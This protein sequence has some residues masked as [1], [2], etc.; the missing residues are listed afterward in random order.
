M[1]PRSRSVRPYLIQSNEV[2]K[3]LRKQRLPSPYRRPLAYTLEKFPKNDS[4]D[5]KNATT[6]THFSPPLSTRINVPNGTANSVNCYSDSNSV[7]PSLSNKFL[8]NRRRTS[9]RS[10]SVPPRNY[11]SSYSGKMD[12]YDSKSTY[13]QRLKEGF[14][15]YQQQNGGRV[16]PVQINADEKHLGFS[17]PTHKRDYSVEPIDSKRFSSTLNVNCGLP[18]SSS[19]SDPYERRRSNSIIS[20]AFSRRQSFSYRNGGTPDHAPIP[21]TN[22]MPSSQFYHDRRKNGVTSTDCE[23]DE[24]PQFAELMQRFSDISTSDIR[25][26]LPSA[27]MYQ[28]PTKLGST[29]TKFSTSTLPPTPSPYRPMHN[30]LNP[31]QPR[32]TTSDA[33]P[34]FREKSAANDG[35]LMLK[36]NSRNS[37]V[38]CLKGLINHGNTCYFSAFIQCLASCEQFAKFFVCNHSEETTDGSSTGQ[39]STN[40]MPLLTNALS[41]TLCCLWFNNSLADSSC[42]RLLQL[43]SKANPQFVFSQ[44]QDAHECLI[45]LLNRLHDEVKEREMHANK[46]HTDN[47]NGIDNGMVVHHHIQ[48]SE[49]E[50][51][52]DAL[53]RVSGTNR[54][55]VM[56]IF[57]AQFRSAV[58]CTNSVC[59]F[60]NLTFDPYLSISLS[61]PL[62]KKPSELTVLFVPFFGA[63]QIIRYH[64]QLADPLY[65][66]W[67]VKERVMQHVRAPSEQSLCCQFQPNGQCQFLSDDDKLDENT[68][69]VILVEVPKL[70]EQQRMQEMVVAIVVFVLGIVPD[71]ERYGNPFVVVLNRHWSYDRISS[72]LF[73]K[74]SF[75]L[76]RAFY[77]LPADYTLLVQHSAEQVACLDPAMAMPLFHEYINNTLSDHHSSVPALKLIVEWSSSVRHEFQRVPMESVA[78]D[79]TFC[80]G[81]FQSVNYDTYG[82][83]E[84]PIPLA[85]LID[86]YVKRETIQDWKCPKCGRSPGRKELKFHSLPD[87]LIFHLKRF[88]L[89]NDGI[90]SK[91]ESR[92]QV[93]LEGLDMGP[94]VFNPD[95]RANTLPKHRRERAPDFL[96]KHPEN[97]IYDLIGV[98]S[99]FGQRTNSGHYTAT[100]RNPLDGQWRTFDDSRVS[101]P[102]GQGDIRVSTKSYLLFYER[103]LH[104]DDQQSLMTVPCEKWFP[105]ALPDHVLA[106]YNNG[107]GPTNA[108]NCNGHSPLAS[109]GVTRLSSAEPLVLENS[110]EK[111]RCSI[112]DGD[113]KWRGSRVMARH[114]GVSAVPHSTPVVPLRSSSVIPISTTATVDNHRN[115]STYSTI[116]NSGVFTRPS[117]ATLYTPSAGRMA[118]SSHSTLTSYPRG[119]NSGT[120]L[121]NG[122]YPRYSNTYHF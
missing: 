58:E 30:S 45:W 85:T 22:N 122:N 106:K 11:S 120:R 110:Y 20:S 74:G 38:P 54:S 3:F 10:P 119:F 84:I 28:F 41:A 78:H 23:S 35:E 2:D 8:E 64:F 89:L 31:L 44:Q 55:T 77:P 92:V 25:P 37:Q 47:E 13:G 18:S 6:N 17:N 107:V 39:S 99:H 121:Q 4:D 52:S 112:D 61:V 34:S 48:K 102:I 93:P 96:H 117:T 43:I 71:G 69:E 21:A 16:I 113:S 14:F 116:K 109:K 68:K 32:P 72:L 88:E 82:Q 56:E 97:S 53:D 101:Q 62:P 29:S 118:I 83:D 60:T 79:Y 104:R 81:R 108:N 36:Q 15:D 51:A 9:G 94:Y 7:Q 91:I 12:G 50:L 90:A 46:K 26:R 115:Y 95:V 105:N 70:N 100:T 87:V 59:A 76:P 98:V 86:D 49:G 75:M 73:E 114:N 27:S 42:Y 111:R 5:N 19:S 66:I 33:Q 67:D 65:T 1:E 63:R 40:S 57:R 103:R 24:P 80:R